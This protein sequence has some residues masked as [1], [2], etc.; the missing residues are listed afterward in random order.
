MQTVIA[1]GKARGPWVQEVLP[2]LPAMPGVYLQGLRIHAADGSVMFEQVLEA[3]VV[4]LCIAFAKAHQ[5]TLT[6]YCG[7]RILCEATDEH[8][9]RLLFYKEPSPEGACRHTL[10]R[11]GVLMPACA[12][13]TRAPCGSASLLRAVYG[14][15]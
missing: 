10:R 12:H 14:R 13:S 7:D 8:T 2:A 4:E 6:A 1:T 11:H 3:N 5:L 15:Q 9:D